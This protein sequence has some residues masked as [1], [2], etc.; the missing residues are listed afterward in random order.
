M[1]EYIIDRPNYNGI[2]FYSVT[3]LSTSKN[4][5]DSILIINSF[6]IN[7]DYE[8]INEIL[9]LFN[10]KKFFDYKITLTTWTEE[11]VQ[12]YNSIVKE[13][14]K[15]IGKFLSKINKNNLSDIYSKIDYVYIEDFW[16]VF[17]EYK[18]YKRISGAVLENV[19]FHNEYDLFIILRNKKLVNRYGINIT[20]VLLKSKYTPE[21]IDSIF[22]SKSDNKHK[23]FL[24]E[25]FDKSNIEKILFDYIH[26]GNYNPNILDRIYT[27]PNN[28]KECPINDKLKLS[29][30]KELQKYWEN[31][32]NASR[33]YY[34][35][36]LC[37]D[38][39]DAIYK[40]VIDKNSFK[41]I[42]D[43]KWF[44]ENLD[45]P[46]LLNNFIYLFGVVDLNFRSC[47][48]SLKSELNILEEHLTSSGKNSYV[49][50][51]DF[52]QKQAISILQATTYYEFLKEQNIYLENVIKWFFEDYLKYEFNIK[53]FFV[54]LSSENTSYLDKCKTISS[55]FDS[56]L[57]QFRMYV[58]DGT[59]DRELFEISSE[60]L[61][62]KDVPSLLNKK[63]VYAKSDNINYIMFLL[64]S[65][66][67]HLNITSKLK[68]HY[69]NCFELIKMQTVCYS[70]F[71]EF[72]LKS[73][74]YLIE[75]DLIN[76]EDDI[77]SLN[78]DKASILHDL[79]YNEV[80]CYWHNLLR[81]KIIDDWITSGDLISESSLFSKPE[82]DYIDFM[83]NKSK[84]SDG[85]DLRNKYIHGTYPNDPKLHKENYM[86]L[87]NIVILTIIKINEEF[88]IIDEIKTKKKVNL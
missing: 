74:D 41:I 61:F 14:S 51:I 58:T 75:N 55:E 60:H 35:I 18:V 83:L 3:D 37:F 2:K 44:K 31:N 42:Y 71:Y 10:I 80:L 7:K 82:Q 30:K 17:Q 76:K 27:S 15:A 69:K 64:F 20:N 40:T 84:F 59:I 13:F 77:L 23:I 54:N 1:E 87:L 16:N 57:K 33:F 5:N 36:Q 29:A 70:D 86:R 34:E 43:I 48:V 6:D 11:E 24:P 28:P 26:S 12:N 63:Y 78:L 67:S 79:Y 25:E 22:L 49:K 19:I 32:E 68:K 38:D 8:N 21:I 9:E 66:Q 65:T 72:Q 81:A 4:L 73:I 52:E 46:T 88:C 53:S 62:V 56:I 47:L 50:G 85:L 39:I 45:N